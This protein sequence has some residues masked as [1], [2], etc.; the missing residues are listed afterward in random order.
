MDFGI[1]AVPA[2]TVLA[3]VV[4]EIVEASKLDN[5]WIPV[6][7]ALFGIGL[8]ILALY[9][10]PDFPTNNVIAAAAVGAVSGFAAT[11]VDQMFKQLK[12]GER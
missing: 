10:M 2:I 4:G 1:A 12:G 6:I 3:Y 7:C 5:K 8:G 9:T 11:G